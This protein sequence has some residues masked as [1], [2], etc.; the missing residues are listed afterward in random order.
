MTPLGT[1][2]NHPNY[3]AAKQGAN[4]DAAFDLVNE[5]LPDEKVHELQ[6][7]SPKVT[8]PKPPVLTQ[9]EIELLRQD[10]KNSM[11]YLINKAKKVYASQEKI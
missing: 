1:A 5:I 7:P 9:S 10:L 4:L 6:T 8:L 11:A 2:A 3:S